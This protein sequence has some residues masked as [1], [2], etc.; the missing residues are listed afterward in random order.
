M[1]KGWNKSVGAVLNTVT[2]SS[3]KLTNSDFT[4]LGLSPNEYVWVSLTDL[5]KLI[6]QV[7]EEVKTLITSS[8]ISLLALVENV[9]MTTYYLMKCEKHS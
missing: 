4:P 9:Q 3:K 2:R 5:W 6:L 7:N 1:K 8:N